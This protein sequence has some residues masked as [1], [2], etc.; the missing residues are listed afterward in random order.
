MAIEPSDSNWRYAQKLNEV[1][2]R[3]NEISDHLLFL[4]RMAFE[5]R[6]RR[7]WSLVFAVFFTDFFRH[8]PLWRKGDIK[9]MDIPP[10]LMTRQSEEQVVETFRHPVNVTAIGVKRNG[11][12]KEA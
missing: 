4:D 6:Q 12:E 5:I 10:D 11:Q 2:T 7:F 1:I 9:Y 8:W 3:Q